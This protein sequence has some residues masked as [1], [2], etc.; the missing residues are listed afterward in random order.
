MTQQ[1]SAFRT[2]HA[3]FLLSEERRVNWRNI[4]KADIGRILQGD[5]RDLNN[6]LEELAY[7]ELEKDPYLSTSQDAHKLMK[8]MQFG[9]QYLLFTQS[10]LKHNLTKADEAVK[11]EKVHLERLGK[12]SQH[13]KRKVKK[14]EAELDRLDQRAH[15]YDMMS[16]FLRP[17]LDRQMDFKALIEARPARNPLPRPPEPDYRPS[18]SQDW[19][20]SADFELSGSY[21]GEKGSIQPPSRPIS[22][23]TE[24]QQSRL[25]R[26]NSP[27]TIE[28]MY[29]PVE[30]DPEE[31]QL[32]G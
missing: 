14:L 3:G 30:E 22:V 9:L 15:H 28:G 31:G 13:Q 4:E 25:S 7:T 12:V 18:G 24:E 6:C 29:G 20:E 21:A 26:F 5:L 17:H 1:A 27:G 16:D 10:V 19:M 11:T 23:I 32:S 2:I 8:V